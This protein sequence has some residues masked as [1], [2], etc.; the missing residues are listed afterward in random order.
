MEKIEAILH[1]DMPRTSTDLRMFI[2][3][4]N[5][6]KDM[7]PSR[8]HMLKPL[9]YLTGLPKRT[10]LNWTSA[11]HNAF[12]KMRYL[13]VADALYAYPDQITTSVLTFT[14]TLQIFN[15]VHLFNARQPYCSIFQQKTE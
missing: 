10:T 4:V 2:G 11:L 6:Y 13:M 7:W 8:A 5:Y 3:C 9:T 15:S 12:D 14:L 1:M